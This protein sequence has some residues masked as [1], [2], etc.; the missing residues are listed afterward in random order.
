MSAAC[1]INWTYYDKRPS[2]RD[3]QQSS[4]QLEG[5]STPHDLLM[6]IVN[7]R[8]YL[9]I[10]SFPL[11]KIAYAGSQIALLTNLVGR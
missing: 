2:S 3:S 5:S 7:C 1:C 4:N 9:D 10:E 6:G 8:P 11:C